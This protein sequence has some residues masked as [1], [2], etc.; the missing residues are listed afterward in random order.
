MLESK[1]EITKYVDFF[2]AKKKFQIRNLNDITGILTSKKYL[3]LV[4]NIYNSLNLKE[5]DLSSYRL[6]PQCY[7]KANQIIDNFWK[8]LLGDQL[9]QE[10][11]SRLKSKLKI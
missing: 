5:E 4:N 1:Q 11:N 7:L 6:S 9:F 2:K 10:F 8:L 3:E